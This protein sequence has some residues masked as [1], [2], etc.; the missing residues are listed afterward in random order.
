MSKQ[1]ASANK[2]QS[3]I[4]LIRADRPI[5]YMLLLWP[6]LWSLMLAGEGQPKGLLIVIFVVGVIVMRSAGCV[7][8]D[9]FDKNIDGYVERTKERPL[10]VGSISVKEAWT[11]FFLLILCAF[12]LVLQLNTKA[13]LYAL[14]GLLLTII[15]PLF[16]RF[17]SAPQMV[18]GI[19]FSWCIPMVYVAS[20]KA[21]DLVFYL[22]WLGTILWIIVYDTF[23]AMADKRDDETVGIFST[24]RLFGNHD[25]FITA[26][27]QGLVVFLFSYV[28]ILAK[29]SFIYFICVFIVLFLFVYQQLLIKNREPSACL[30]AFLV[31]NYVGGSIFIGVLSQ[32][33]F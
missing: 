28:G 32:Q 21:F 9:I 11:I 20:E 27:L 4:Q 33:L 19:T 25:K 13:L 26:A 15:Y 7:I 16:K 10:V 17:F 22:M 24:A 3:V 2:T 12:L 31:N 5:G 6:T 1:L 8:N 30:K 14:I 23:Y 29:M 18:L